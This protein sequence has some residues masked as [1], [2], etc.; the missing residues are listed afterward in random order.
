MKPMA[1]KTASKKSKKKPADK[2]ARKKP[3]VAATK[4]KP[5]A[6]KAA[7]K[8]AKKTA[9]KPT[10]EKAAPKKA[11]SKRR[12][13]KATTG[14]D[15]QRKPGS[16]KLS[17]LHSDILWYT[18][19][20]YADMRA[21]LKGQP[22]TEQVI[23]AV[24]RIAAA[25]KKAKPSS[26][27]SITYYGVEYRENAAELAV[28]KVVTFDSFLST[29]PDAKV[30]ERWA[31]H[32]QMLRISVPKGSRFRVLKP[33]ESFVPSDKEWLFH[34]LVKV[35]VK[36]GPI[37]IE[38]SVVSLWDVELVD[39][40]TNT[41]HVLRMKTRLDPKRL[42][43]VK[44]AIEKLKE[45]GTDSK[46][47]RTIRDR[48]LK[49]AYSG[50]DRLHMDA[51]LAI[52]EGCGLQKTKGETPTAI[53]DE[54]I[55][56]LSGGLGGADTTSP[57][58]PGD[59]VPD[60]HSIVDRPKFDGH[61]KPIWYPDEKPYRVVPT[62][63]LSSSPWW[64]TK[65]TATFATLSEARAYTAKLTESPARNLTE[66]SISLAVNAET[67]KKNGKWKAVEK[68]E[69]PKKTAARAKVGP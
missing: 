63:R 62:Y 47:L 39:D 55:D 10:A 20:G 8:T 54:I 30:A 12:T 61:G 26:E 29:S 36:K 1:K 9:K 28:G 11:A 32:K 44:S 27:P 37:P 7:K 46:K 53:I 38:G 58:H 67:W 2:V 4:K 64:H 14:A 21:A 13:A 15:A 48:L 50:K 42:R 57:A 49:K 66:V 6:T 22:A 45:A 23:A 51:I 34:P 52:A 31:G 41:K 17:P 25:I 33:V 40:G 18:T 60:T 19:N 56:H 5:A 24:N 68:W 3:S 65:G 59:R 35:L 69:R 16:E 43:V